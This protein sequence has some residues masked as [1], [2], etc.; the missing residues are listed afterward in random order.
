[1]TGLNAHIPTPEPP[2]PPRPEP[3]DNPTDPQPPREPPAPLPG[4]LPRK[5]NDEPLP[6]GDPVKPIQNPPVSATT[7]SY[8]FRL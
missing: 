4:D 3:P 2:Q 5:P 7:R 6:I 8:S 1:M